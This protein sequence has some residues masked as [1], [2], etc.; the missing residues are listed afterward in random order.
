MAVLIE[1]SLY[2]SNENLQSSSSSSSSSLVHLLEIKEKEEEEEFRRLRG[3]SPEKGGSLTWYKVSWSV[4]ITENPLAKPW[5]MKN[6]TVRPSSSYVTGSYALWPEDVRLDKRSFSS[7]SDPRLDR[8]VNQLMYL[9]RGYRPEAYQPKGTLPLKKILLYFG[10]GNWGDAGLKLGQGRF[11]D[12]Q[13][14]VSSCSLVDDV[15]AISEADAV[16]F[17]DRFSWPRFGRPLGQLWILFLLEGP[18]HTQLFSSIQENTFN[19]T[20]TYRHDS[21]LV[22]PYEKFVTYE[23]LYGGVDEGDDEGDLMPENVDLFRSVMLSDGGDNN[24]NVVKVS[25]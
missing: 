18:R 7:S 2:N 3:S 5:F 9:P 15:E 25:A 6:G 8:I 21:D 23:S 16:I 22:T 12:D 19:W 4:N 10:K 1:R 20:A 13:C 17:K 14:P 11:L 24:D